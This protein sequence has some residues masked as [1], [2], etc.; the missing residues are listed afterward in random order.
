[1]QV[2]YHLGAHFT[3][4]DRLLKCLLKNKGPL[5]GEGI[6]VPGPSRYRAL[7]RE[8]VLA[9]RGKPAPEETQEE[10]IDTVTEGGQAERL[11]FSN[12]SFLCA[13][14]KVLHQGKLYATADQKTHWL[15][16]VFPDAEV[17]F[18]LSVR[19]PATFVPAVFAHCSDLSFEAFRNGADPRELLWSPVVQAIR[20]ANPDASLTVWC[21]EDTPLIWPELLREI[22]GHDPYTK[23]KGTDDFLASI[24]T[25]SGMKRMRAY[26]ESHPPAN[27]IQRRRIV[28][29]FLDKFALDEE[30]EM[31]LDLPGWTED[32]VE[33]TTEIYEEDMFAI[34]RMPGVTFIAP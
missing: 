29:A 18:H 8:T 26:L 20:D 22:S 25:E 2:V 10:I 15:G 1:M 23:L 19:N 14:K 34:E 33:E 3:D 7:L 4:E 9:L 27:E 31:E 21:N 6:I 13:T 28:A 5:A 11:I 16:Q 12:Q 17:E 32:L 30:V 24:M